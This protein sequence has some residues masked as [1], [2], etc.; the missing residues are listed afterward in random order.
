MVDAAAILGPR[1]YDWNKALHLWLDINEVGAV[2]AVLRRWRDS[3]ELSGHGQNND[4][5]FFIQYQ[6]EH[7]FAKVSQRKAGAGIVR[8]V[9]IIPRDAAAICI[10]LLKLLSAEYPTIPLEEILAT[11]RA[12]HRLSNAATA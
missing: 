2:I 3:V 6:Q 5:S 12:T 8:G 10:L 9:K 4:K 7:F 11:V 1:N